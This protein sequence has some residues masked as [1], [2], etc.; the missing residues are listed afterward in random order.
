MYNN[1]IATR[2]DSVARLNNRLGRIYVMQIVRAASVIVVAIVSCGLA[3]NFLP[4][5]LHTA[6]RE[7]LYVKRLCRS[8]C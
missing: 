7:I 4:F 5:L 6:E 1:F 2:F 8:A 3:I